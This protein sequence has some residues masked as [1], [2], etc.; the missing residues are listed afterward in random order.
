MS[1]MSG[2][3]RAG[4]ARRAVVALLL[5][6]LTLG[7]APAPPAQGLAVATKAA[8]P[9]PILF[10]TQV[11]I[12]EDFTTIGSVFGNHRGDVQ[13]AGR[14]GDLHILYPNGA[15]RNLTHEAGFGNEGFQG[16]GGIAVREPCVHW[17]GTKALFS[18]VVGATTERYEYIDIWWQIYEVTGLGQSER[19]V[20]TRVPRQPADANN[21]SPLYAP[22]GRILFTSDRPRDGARHLYPQLDEYEEVPTNTGLWSLDPATGD[23]RLLDHAPSGAFRPI[24]DRYGRVVYTRWDHLERDQQADAEGNPYGTFDYANESAVAARLATGVEI[25]P[26]PRAARQDLLAGT[27]FEGHGFNHFFPWQINPDGTEHETL[28]HIGRHELHEYFNRDRHDDDELSE[29]IA[30]NSSRFNPN[31]IESL[32]QIQEDPRTPGRYVGVDAPEFRT[33]ASGRLVALDSPAGLAADRIAVT[34]LTHPSTVEVTDEGDSPAAGSTGHYRNPL[35]LSDGSL[36]AVHAAETRADENTGTRQKPASRYAFRIK[37]LEPGP[38]GYWT[39]GAPLTAGIRKTVSYW[40]PDEM[41]TY[42]GELWELDPVEV[43]A[44]PAPPARTAAFEEPERRTFEQEGVD[45]ESFRAWLRANGLAVMVSR[46]VTTRDEADRQQPFNLQVAGGGARTTGT[47]GRLYAV[48][49]L[50]IF[51]ADQLRGLGGVDDPRPGRRVLARVMHDSK[52]RNPVAGGPA[53]SVRVAPDG[54]AAAFVPA[55][56]ALT[57]QLTDAAGQGVVRERYWL[58][59]QPGEVRVCTSCHGPNSR[60][61]QGKAPATNSPE[62]LRSLLRFW[63]T[64]LGGG[65]GC[66]PGPTAL[67]LNGGRFRVEAAWK[68]FSGNAGAGRALPLTADTGAFWFF[69]PKNVEVVLK[70]LDGRGV[71]GNFWVYYGALSNVEYT[72]T[73]TDTTT[74]AAKTYRN[75]AG[76]FASAG[77]PGALPGKSAATIAAN[78]VFSNVGEG[79]VPSRAGTSTVPASGFES[80][81]TRKAACSAGPTALCLNGGR[82][83]IEIDWKDFSGATGTAKASALTGDT[84]TFWFFDPKNIEVVVKVLDARAL[85]GRWWVF[86]GAL[87]NVEY[88]VTVTDTATN[89]RKTYHNP[90][91]RFASVGDTAAFPGGP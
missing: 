49:H 73:I 61:Q 24:L 78:A 83:R 82:F 4:P 37:R 6:P 22:D 19:A 34:Y 2:A 47:A 20:I 85:N 15:L 18:M 77:D 36:V 33:H 21:V 56:R 53:G 79:L 14:G 64:E 57:W 30:Y 25:F 48:S 46:N 16:S 5:I 65:A 69:D 52:A 86:F 71:N 63:K 70:V 59:F 43:R 7:A 27:P 68:D 23:L 84:G 45:S 90:A 38:G 41:V 58:T 11:P 54:S 28:N 35:P 81:A 88:T 91:G 74:G 51:Q 12:P 13:S 66:Q 40:D 75:P 3:F 42:S 8:L 29:F 31:P 67:C 50:Q 55:R 39:A 89:A 17:S 80:L 10:V 62:A 76:T 87:S 9:S 44:R 32:L 26:E 60:D 1:P 72:L